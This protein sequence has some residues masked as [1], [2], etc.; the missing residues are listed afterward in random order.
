MSFQRLAKSG[1]DQFPVGQRR[2]VTRCLLIA[3]L[4]I[5]FTV[6]AASQ[7][8]AQ[9]VASDTDYPTVAALNAAVLP[10]R[11]RVE[12]AERLRGVTNI[13][14]TPASAVTRQVGEQQ[15]FTAANSTDNTVLTIPAT[16]RVVGEHIYLWV[17]NGANVND[18]D[19]Q[20]LARR[21]RQQHLSQGCAICGAAKRTPGIDGDP[22]IYGLF[23]H[24]LGA[25]TAAYFASDHTY[26]KVG[27]ADQQRTRDVL[28]QPRRDWRR[29]ST[30]A[31]SKASSRTNSS[32]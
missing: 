18:A 14:P 13:A 4:V 22:H 2:W 19:L 30:A 6:P 8:A 17:E 12:L 21:F 5:L 11:D 27:R 16:L 28:L 25:S 32:T 23:A 31:R 7:I 3:A 10:P 15:V 26:P 1:S 29:S 9:N 24:G 20:A